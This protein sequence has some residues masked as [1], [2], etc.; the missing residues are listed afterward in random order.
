MERNVVDVKQIEDHHVTET[1]FTPA[2]HLPE[3]RAARCHGEPALVPDCV[4]LPFVG[5]AMGA[6]RRGSYPLQDVQHLGEFVN[7]GLSDKAPDPCDVA[8]IDDFRA[9][10]KGCSFRFDKIGGVSPFGYHPGRSR[11]AW[12]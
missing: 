2:K 12:I 5:E 11:P 6:A 7:A 9:G 3:P 10:G 1:D 8:L 4:V